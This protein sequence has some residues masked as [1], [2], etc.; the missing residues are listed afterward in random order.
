[1]RKYS[2][3]KLISDLTYK[4]IKGSVYNRKAWHFSVADLKAKI[5]AE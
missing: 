3:L 5:N 4:E 2:E 1:M